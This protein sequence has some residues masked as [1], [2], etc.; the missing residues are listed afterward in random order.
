MRAKRLL[1]VSL[2]APALAGRAPAQSVPRPLPTFDW[3][4]SDDVRRVAAL[5]TSVWLSDNTLLIY[6]SRV[7]PAQRKFE[8][9]D[10]ATGQ[11]R[12]AFSIP[13][14]LRSLNALLPPSQPLQSLAWPESF[15]P[16]GKHALY[17]IDGDL[18]VLDVASSRFARITRTDSAE[19]SAEFS[20]DGAQL[21]FVRANDLHT[22]NLTTGAET[23]LT[24]SGNA[25]TLNGTLSWLYWEEI[26]GRRD[27]GYWW[28]PDSK[29]IA[30]LQTDESKVDLQT[31]VDFAPLTPRV[32][33]QRYP[34][35]GRP[36]PKARVGIV[37]AIGGVTTWVTIADK[38]FDV[39]LRVKWVP[40]NRRLS[41][42]TMTRNQREVGVYIADRATGAAKRII[43]ETD[44]GYVNIH[45]DLHFIPG[46]KELLWASERD[47]FYHIYRYTYDG[48]LVNQVTRG[49]WSLASSGGVFWVRQSV[50]GMSGEWMY[51]TALEKS[52]VER[53]LYR[54]RLDGSAMA[55]LSESAGVH[56]I[57]MSPNARYYT[58]ASSDARTLPSLALR[59][60]ESAPP[61]TLASPRTELLANIDMQYPEMT[62]IPARDG[63]AMPAR[64]LRPRNFRASEK[65]PVIM[66]VYG[67]ASSATVFD[68]WQ[69]DVMF[70]QLL[71]AEGYVVVKIDNRTATAVSKKLEN[72][73]VGKLGDTE[74]ADLGDAA[75]WLKRQPWV[76]SSRV[77]VWG[78]SNG[79]YITLQL[80][81]RTKEFKAGIAVA[82]VT[83]WRFYDSK[84]AEAF[85]GMP[86]ANPRGYDSASVVTRAADLHGRL[87]VIHGTYDDNVQPQNTQAFFNAV[88]KA[89]KTFEMMLYPMRK[90]GIDDRDANIHVYRTMLEFWRRAL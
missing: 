4:F 23:R 65:H 40:D 80:M 88:I 90:H 55:R 27:I 79:G 71:L 83:D 73:A 75:R 20:P 70:Y 38:P 39:V 46:G 43:T 81:T 64:I 50:L 6:D 25:T 84:W 77:G 19:H 53:H 35:A 87:M 15:D 34:K 14:A 21:A 60:V 10:P 66:A 42:Q 69:N 3:V 49:Q 17:V 31:F 1:A 45:D 78:W 22:V 89:G 44:P 30:Y 29:T 57:N 52:S 47:G 8:V 5:P 82:P 68:G 2:V 63:F 62:T 11:R 86:D 26:F 61:R 28:S 41:V 67:G 12:D 76:D 36:N 58:D 85:L 9:I 54:V 48:A 7:P 33:T 56:R 13:D 24:R 37:N 32:I 59:S 72:L 18:F 16:A 74:T 51:F